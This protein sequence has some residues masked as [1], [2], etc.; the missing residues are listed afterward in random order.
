MQTWVYFV[1]YLNVCRF[2][3]TSCR[4]TMVRTSLPRHYHSAE[5]VLP[6]FQNLQ[7]A[8]FHEKRQCDALRHSLSMLH[9]EREEVE[10]EQRQ[11]R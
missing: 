5:E 6:K 8:I 9:K 3:F 2:Y 10:L 11:L 1:S 4:S 7:H